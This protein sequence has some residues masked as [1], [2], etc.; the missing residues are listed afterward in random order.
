MLKGKRKLLQ[1][2]NKR[3]CNCHVDATQHPKPIYNGAKHSCWEHMPD[4]SHRGAATVSPVNAVCIVSSTC[5]TSGLQRACRL[6]LRHSSRWQCNSCSDSRSNH[7]DGQLHHRTAQP[8]TRQIRD[9]TQVNLNATM[10]KRLPP[11]LTHPHMCT[12]DLD[13]LLLTLK[14]FSAKPT[15]MVNICAQFR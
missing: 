11:P 9:F 5:V 8:Y 13:R 12:H 6:R 4:T 2:V 10:L 15:H 7:S 14:T 1:Y 3:P